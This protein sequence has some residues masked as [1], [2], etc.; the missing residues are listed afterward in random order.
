MYMKDGE[1]AAFVTNQERKMEVSK[2]IKKIEKALGVKVTKESHNSGKYHGKYYFSHGDQVGSFLTQQGY[3]EDENG[4][5]GKLDHA[6]AHNWHIRSKNDHSDIQS[7]YFAGHFVSNCSQ[8]VRNFKP[9]TPKFAVGSLVRGKQNKRA[10]RQGYAGKVGL[11]TK[12]GDYMNID[13]VGV[14]NPRYVM[15]YPQ[16]DM[17]LVSAAA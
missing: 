9:P 16:R 5:Y 7:D 15:T 11:V 1:R 2:A 6:E 17:E 13:W 8:L 10:I 14:E 3:G 12:T 4:V